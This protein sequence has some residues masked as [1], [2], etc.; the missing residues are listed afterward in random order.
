MSTNRLSDHIMRNNIKVRKKNT[1]KEN[2][3]KFGPV[4]CH[5]STER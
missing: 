3:G 5:E 2:E 1:I 4:T